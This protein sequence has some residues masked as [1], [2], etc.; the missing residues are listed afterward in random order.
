MVDFHA[1]DDLLEE[2]LVAIYLPP[3][4]LRDH[5]ACARR[6]EQQTRT[7]PKEDGRARARHSSVLL[8]GRGCAVAMLAGFPASERVTFAADRQTVL[9]DDALALARA[10]AEGIRVLVGDAPP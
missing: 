2:P 5:E 6:A 7:D 8:R 9:G 10:L 4:P 1:R 3:P